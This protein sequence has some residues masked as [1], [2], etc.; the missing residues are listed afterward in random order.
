M[1]EK[2]SFGYTFQNVPVTYIS[3]NGYGVQAIYNTL[4]AM[5]EIINKSIRNWKVRDFATWV[6]RNVA[7]HDKAEEA[8]AV[9]DFVQQKVRYCYDPSGL[10]ML[11]TPDVLIDKIRLGNI[12]TEDC[13]GF[14][15]LSLSLLKSLGFPVALRAAGYK[16]DKK[17]SHVYGLVRIKNKWVPFDAIR[18]E[19]SLG[20]EAPN[21]TILKDVE[22]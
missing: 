9:F 7:P 12:P 13:D 5:K 4:D 11:T 14:T 10:E 6:V 16:P 17:F 3:D 15:I 8:R 2:G 18:E 21:P 20:M 22:V 19:F 1:F